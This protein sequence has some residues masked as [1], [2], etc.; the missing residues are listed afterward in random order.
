[1]TVITAL[2]DKMHQNRASTETGSCCSFS[3]TGSL[4]TRE[5]E[6]RHS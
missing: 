6:Q 1:M 3:N 2:Y 5:K 4:D